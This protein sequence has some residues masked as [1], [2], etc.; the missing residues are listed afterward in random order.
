M[1]S[2]KRLVFVVITSTL[3]LS[4]VFLAQISH[5]PT[6]DDWLPLQSGKLNISG[7][8]DFGL[9]HTLSNS[10]YRNPNGCRF[11]D[12]EDMKKKDVDLRLIVITYAR[13][14]SLLRLIESLNKANYGNANVMLEVWIDRSKSQLVHSETLYAMRDATFSKGQCNIIVHPYHVGIRGQWL[15]VSENILLCSSNNRD[16]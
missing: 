10:F 13:P 9:R 14:A 15:T 6:S 8:F 2:R 4:L 3:F 5:Y 1:V 11:T 16:T 12:F 7:T